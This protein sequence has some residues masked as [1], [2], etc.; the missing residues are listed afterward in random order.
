MKILHFIDSGGLY[1]AEKML[2]ALCKEQKKAGLEVTILSCGELDEPEKPIENE[3]KKIGLAVKAWRMNPGL[4]ITGMKAVWQWVHEQQF[5][6]L[7][8][9][10]YKFNVLL[11]LTKSKKNNLPICCTVHGYVNSPFPKKGWFYETIDKLAISRL[12]A[13]VRVNQLNDLSPIQK[14]LY[15]NK[16]HQIVNGIEPPPYVLDV[17]SEPLKKLLIVGRLSVE[18]GHADLIQAMATLV[19]NNK[20]MTLTIAGDGPL[21]SV[22]IELTKTLKLEKHI[23]FLGFVNDMNALY[24]THDALVMPSYTEGLPITLLEAV[25]RKLPVFV[26]PVGGVGEIIS[27]RRCTISVGDIQSISDRVEIWQSLV[28]SI[29]NLIVESHYELFKKYYT[30]TTMATAYFKLYTKLIDNK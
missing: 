4:N 30:S 10:G 13:I 9:H 22:L 1:G 20:E 27:D 23:N 5:T 6:V 24:Q 3:A 11:A 15:G 29:R 26:T 25:S 16:V 8:S 2:L 21:K 12:D 19:K 17:N 28:R 14:W 7:H 18:K